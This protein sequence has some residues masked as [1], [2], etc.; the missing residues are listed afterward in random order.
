MVPR[1]CFAAEAGSRL[2][3]LSCPNAFCC[4]TVCSR[5][6]KPHM[7]VF[8]PTGLCLAVLSHLFCARYSMFAAKLLT[9]MMAA[10]LGTQV[11]ALEV[12]TFMRCSCFFFQSPEL[13]V[14]VKNNQPH[15]SRNTLIEFGGGG[16]WVRRGVKGN[17]S[18][19]PE[20]GICELSMERY[21]IIAHKKIA[22]ACHKALYCQLICAT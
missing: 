1:D 21:Y 6:I 5:I 12:L 20:K 14:Q 18:I 17:D 13:S 7:G 8:V 19:G 11:G 4:A 10:S 2:C 9:H 15:M 22:A 3:V 16:G